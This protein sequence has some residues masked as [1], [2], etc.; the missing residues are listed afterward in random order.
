[1]TELVSM[2]Q[3]EEKVREKVITSFA[4]LLPEEVFDSLVNSAIKE[5]FEDSTKPFTLRKEEARWGNSGSVQALVSVTPFK[6]LVWEK[7][8][9]IT[10]K[11]LNIYFNDRTAEIEKA[12]LSRYTESPKLRALENASIELLMQRQQENMF[13]VMMISALEAFKMQL[14][15]SFTENGVPLNIDSIGTYV[16]STDQARRNAHHG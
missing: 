14:G 1:M 11:A 3:L 12:M 5:Y 9:D 10:Q 2:K 16:M 8:H 15:K 4:S 13:Q 6:F 7:L